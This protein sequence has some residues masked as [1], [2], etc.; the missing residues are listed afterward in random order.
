DLYQS[1]LGCRIHRRSR[2][3]EAPNRVDVK[4]ISNQ[5]G[6]A[7]RAL[8]NGLRPIPGGRFLFSKLLG[9]A[10]PYTG[11]V[12]AQI[13]DLAPGYARV[14]LRDRRSVRNHL[15]SIHAIA[16]ANL[17][18]MGTGLAFNVG[19]PDGARGIL[20]GISLEYV[21]KARGR[22]TIECRCDPPQTNER[23]EFDV[24]GV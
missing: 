19:L 1:Q 8:W 11:T 18:E 2:K 10:A 7:L 21:K 4:G 6:V 20:T 15:G 5:P 14:A 16:L 22:L 23:R 24:A 13:V 17:A 9:V 12:G 3:G